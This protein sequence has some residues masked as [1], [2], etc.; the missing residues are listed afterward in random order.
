[1]TP[2]FIPT[3]T[4]SDDTSNFDEFEKA[5]RG[6]EVED[7]TK[8]TTSFTG[9]DLPFVGFTYTKALKTQERYGII[10]GLLYQSLHVFNQLII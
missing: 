2:P 9:R 1:M 6:P 10:E 8:K 3:V 7:F 5:K 4:S